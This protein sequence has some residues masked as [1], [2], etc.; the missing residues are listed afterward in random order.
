MGGFYDY[1]KKKWY[2]S[3]YWNE[4]QKTKTGFGHTCEMAQGTTNISQILNNWKVHST[5]NHLNK[6]N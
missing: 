4:T 5:L 6:V 3:H 2:M 1:I